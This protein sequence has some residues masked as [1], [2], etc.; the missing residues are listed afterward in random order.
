MAKDQQIQ[1]PGIFGGLMRYDAE[2]ASKFMIS[3]A[4]AIAFIAGI[5]AFVL[6][7]KIFFPVA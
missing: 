3:P 6:I 5:I 2:Y 7:L 1:M 4:A